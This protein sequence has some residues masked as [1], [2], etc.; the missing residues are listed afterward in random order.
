MRTSV[1]GHAEHDVY[2]PSFDFLSTA[3]QASLVRMAA[4]RHGERYADGVRG[5]DSRPP[6]GGRPNRGA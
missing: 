2:C 3:Q 5:E 1:F 4:K 6:R